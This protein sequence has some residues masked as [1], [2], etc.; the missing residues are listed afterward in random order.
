MELEEMKNTWQEMSKRMQHQEILTTRLI[1]NLSQDKYDSK[2][3]KIGYSEYIGTIICYIGAA[4][5]LMNFTKIAA[6]LMQVF[7]VIAIGL[8]FI[9]PIISLQSYRAIKG[10]K[11]SAKSYLETINDF[12]KRKIKFQKLQRLNVSL[13]LLLMLVA[14][15]VLSA[16]QGKTLDQNPYFWPLI[17]PVSIAFFLVF[18]FWVL[19][20]YDKI[21]K[22][23]EAM[24]RDINSQ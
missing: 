5:V 3:S 8:L 17:F 20:S 22:D 15:P 4:Y 13:G 24:L 14:V 21:L 23:T 11:P 12:G 10:I 18:S 16:I 6:M 19:R 1:E 2:M 7:A 9:L